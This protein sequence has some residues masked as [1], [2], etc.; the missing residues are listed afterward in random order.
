MASH[1]HLGMREHGYMTQFSLNDTLNRAL[2]FMNHSDTS[3]TLKNAVL[4]WANKTYN[5]HR[6]DYEAVWV[7]LCVISNI[8]RGADGVNPMTALHSLPQEPISWECDGQ[9]IIARGTMLT[10]LGQ[11]A[12]CR[13]EYKHGIVAFWAQIYNI[14]LHFVRCSA[15]RGPFFGGIKL[16]RQ[17]FT[18]KAQRRLLRHFYS[19]SIGVTAFRIVLC[20]CREC[21]CYIITPGALGCAAVSA[22][23]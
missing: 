12:G 2:C 23:N 19:I 6:S 16:W 7:W 1:K 11:V 21:N 14:F 5:R 18:L 17:D 10:S 9:A 8:Q 20:T 13:A 22:D 3:K 15:L 4:I